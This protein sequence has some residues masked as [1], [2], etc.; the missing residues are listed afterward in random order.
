MSLSASLSNAM[1]GLGAVSRAAELVSA[2]VA[3]AMTEG[4][5]RRE[6]SLS[7]AV[8]GGQGAGVQV[9]GVERVVNQAAVTDR[10]LAQA[11]LSFH[12]ARSETLNSL[13]QLVGYP[14]SESSLSAFA[15]RFEESLIVASADPSSATGL[16]YVVSSAVGLSAKINEI[17][18]HLH[19]ER[20]SVDNSIGTQVAQLNS[21]LEDVDRLNLEVS[22]QVNSGGD[23]SGLL[24][25]RQAI[26]DSISSIVP[27]QTVIRDYGQIALVTPNGTTLVD[28]QA[29]SFEFSST[30]IITP[31]MSLESGALS[32]LQIYGASSVSGAAIEA[33]S[34]GSLAALFELRDQDIPQLQE[35]LDALARDLME[36]SASADN[37]L[38]SGEIGLFADDGG[39]LDPLL[40]AG[41]ASRLSV[42]SGVIASEGGDVNKLR[43]GLNATTVGP[44]SDNTIL[45][46][47]EQYFSDARLPAS[48]NFPSAA[49]SSGLMSQFLSQI[50]QDRQISEQRQSYEA[51]RV[52]AFQDVELSS[53]VD[54]DQEMQ[55]LL[56]IERNYAANAKV[57]Q[58]VDEMLESLLRI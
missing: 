35:N 19:G 10:R 58:A 43:D 54:T 34:G 24:D 38:V 8:V 49:S 52:Q 21:A 48:G 29:A 6:L 14:N 22:K 45:T 53:G 25:Q 40:E 42:N 31:D 13:E 56:L 39:A 20:E 2:N 28:Y 18:E 32:G 36:R 17:S 47:Y 7:A 51:A 5:G 50:S 23:P 46:A 1:S 15:D 3:N 30:S 11:E 33:I 9:S 55:K 44:A 16:N 12:G 4:Y 41:L 37:T 26:V 57:I 27:V